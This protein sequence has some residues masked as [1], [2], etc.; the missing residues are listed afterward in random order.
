M[1]LYYEEKTRLLLQDE[2]DILVNLC[3]SQEIDKKVTN[4]LDIKWL[5][6]ETIT[7]NL[8]CLNSRRIRCVCSQKYNDRSM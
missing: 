1:P 5:C 3:L 4:Q 6:N 8:V 7:T 2:Q